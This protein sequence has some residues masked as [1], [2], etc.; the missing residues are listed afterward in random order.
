MRVVDEKQAKTDGGYTVVVNGEY[1]GAEE[2]DDP[3]NDEL[4]SRV[5]VT[6]GGRACEVLGINHAAIRC[7]APEGSGSAPVVANVWGLV[8]NVVRFSY[9][10]PKIDDGTV[11]SLPTSGGMTFMEGK[12]F[13]DADSY[14]SFALLR[15][16]VPMDNVVLEAHVHLLI[17][18][19]VPPGVGAGHRIALNVSG[20]LSESTRQ[21]AAISSKAM[22][23]YGASTPRELAG[24]F[25]CACPLAGNA[26]FRPRRK[27][28]PRTPYPS[29][30]GSCRTGRQQAAKM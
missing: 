9:A 20:Q 27:C 29:S 5:N 2:G 14:S 22:K 12:N 15:N 10:R 3:V 30:N 19:A 7:T 28:R 11:L 16:G 1:L 13:A 18:F 23:P 26:A 8:S 24:N 17:G 4:R 21:P 6:V 25:L